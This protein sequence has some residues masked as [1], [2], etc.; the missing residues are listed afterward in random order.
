MI[1]GGPDVLFLFLMLSVLLPVF[2]AVA[3]GKLLT[4]AE[5][6]ELLKVPKSWIYQGISNGSLPFRHCKVGRHFVRF[7]QS[8][9]AEYI[10]QQLSAGERTA[11]ARRRLREVK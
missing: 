6:A 10:E 7:L 3:V 8:D 5:V 2:A 4:T 11:E 9:V 1:V